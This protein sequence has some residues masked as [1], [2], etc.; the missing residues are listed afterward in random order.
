[1][2]C[3]V[4][5]DESTGIVVVHVEGEP[6]VEEIKDAMS[7]I[8]QTPEYRSNLRVLWDVRTGNAA[9][10]SSETLRDIARFQR[11]KRPELPQSRVA[12][13]VARE[14]DFGLMRMLGAFLPEGPLQENVFRDAETAWQWLTS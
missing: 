12:I 14:V 7:K 1:M 6:D 5:V 4:G 8:W 13:L 11:D 10:L 2:P 9:N 3:T